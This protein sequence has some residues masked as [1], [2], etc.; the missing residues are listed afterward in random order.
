MAQQSRSLLL[1]V[2][3]VYAFLVTNIAN[4]G[5]G[6]GRRAAW[7]YIASSYHYHGSHK[8]QQVSFY[9]YCLRCPRAPMRSDYLLGVATQD[10]VLYYSWE[11]ASIHGVSE[12]YALPNT[13]YNICS[14]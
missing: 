12:A 13:I 4:S 8:M 10:E 2:S 5:Q 11:L 9:F 14:N 3:L 1:V 7:W 6:T